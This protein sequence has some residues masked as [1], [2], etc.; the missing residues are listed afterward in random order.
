MAVSKEQWLE[1]LRSFLP[2]WFFEEEGYQLAHFEGVAKVL[3]Q[4]SIDLDEHFA[5]TFILSSTTDTL[6]DHGDER[7]LSRFTNEFDPSYRF[8]VQNIANQSNCPAIKSLVDKL[9]IAGECTIIEDFNATVF[10]NREHYLNRGDILIEAIYNAF[11]IIVD[12][13]LHTPYSFANRLFFADREN[14]VGQAD[15]SQFVFDLIVEAVNKV[16][17]AGTVYRVI[18]L[19]ER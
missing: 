15:S 8:R 19:L 5:E 10:L 18:E 3:E 4:L 17:A 1:R 16:K 11:S 2:V 13:Q 6:D 9:L 12:R 7:S 14:Y